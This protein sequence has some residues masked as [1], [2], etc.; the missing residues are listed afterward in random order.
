MI[1]RSCSRVFV[2]KNV[3]AFIVVFLTIKKKNEEPKTQKEFSAFIIDY[4]TSIS[5]FTYEILIF[6]VVLHF[7]EGVADHVF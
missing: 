2:E 7:S 5:W 6:T 4:M 1:Y 3:F